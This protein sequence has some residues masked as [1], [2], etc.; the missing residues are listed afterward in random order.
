M[1]PIIVGEG[2]THW[3]IT[4]WDLPCK[5]IVCIGQWGSPSKVRQVE[6]KCASWL[7]GRAISDMAKHIDRAQSH[8]MFIDCLGT[9]SDTLPWFHD[10]H[11]ICPPVCVYL[12]RC[13]P[14][15]LLPLP[16]KCCLHGVSQ[17]KPIVSQTHCGF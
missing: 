10:T 6:A 13:R 15:T 16:V 8:D 12:D 11:H 7:V 5:L 4:H 2:A 17:D 14:A 1:T 3:D 9:Q